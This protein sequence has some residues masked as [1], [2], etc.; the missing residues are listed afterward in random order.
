[1]ADNKTFTLIG[2]FDDQITKK[3]KDLNKEL[4]KLSKPLKNNNAAASLR[5]GFKAANSELKVLQDQ[6]K[7]LNKLEFKFD[8]SGIQAAREEVQMLGKD[9][10]TVSRKGLPID[11]SGLQ[12]AQEDAKIL[13][14][15]L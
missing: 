9:L 8:K 13:G 12:A 14:K 2:K 4:E 10:D 6:M 5:D 1:M 11:R 3:L 7:S 15:I